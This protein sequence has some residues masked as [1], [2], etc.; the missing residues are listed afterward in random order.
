LRIRGPG[1]L[2]GTAQSGALRLRI[3]DP[4]RDFDLLKDAR[5]DAFA[6]VESDPGF[7]EPGHAIYRAVLERA[8][9]IGESGPG[10]S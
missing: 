3:A 8:P 2:S 5:K 4:L 10:H 6:L 1:E 9:P 7:L